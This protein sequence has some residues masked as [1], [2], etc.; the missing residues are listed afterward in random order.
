MLAFGIGVG[1][2]PCMYNGGHFVLHGNYE[3]GRI[4]DVSQWHVGWG[5]GVGLFASWLCSLDA[6]TGFVAFASFCSWHICR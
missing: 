5:S 3:Y 2:V 1:Y 4:S 6:G